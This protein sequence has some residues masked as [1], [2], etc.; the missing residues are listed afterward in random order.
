MSPGTISADTVP[1]LPPRGAVWFGMSYKESRGDLTIQG[2]TSTFGPR[3]SIA[4][5]AHFSAPAGSDRLALTIWRSRNGHLVEIYKPIRVRVRNGAITEL[6]KRTRVAN[7]ITLGARR[8]GWYRLKYSRGAR[9][10]AS[11][12]FYLKVKHKH[13]FR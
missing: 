3:G 6:G 7:L 11:G 1:G 2:R 13:A 8:S 12:S 10:L 5:V 9:G 4:W